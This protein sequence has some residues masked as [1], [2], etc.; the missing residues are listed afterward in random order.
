MPVVG[1]HV[2]GPDH[3]HRSEGYASLSRPE[4]I[5]ATID[6]APRISELLVSYVRIA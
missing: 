3:G 1:M 4:G 5:G 2:G 6:S